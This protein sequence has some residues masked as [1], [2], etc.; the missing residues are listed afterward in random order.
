MSNIN[1][2]KGPLSNLETAAHSEGAL[3]F[4]LNND[5]SK[6]HLY[7]DNGTKYIN[8]VPE[9]LKI[10]NGGT[11]ATTAADALAN[12]GGLPLAGGTMTGN[13]IF[14]NS[15]TT[16]QKNE[17][18][19][20]WATI[21]SNKPYIGF[22]HDQT[23]GTFIICSTEKDTTTNGVKNY[24]N[25]L[26]IGGGTGNL[27][28]K[29]KQ[30][31]TTDMIP[32]I[33][34]SL[35]NPQALTIQGNGTTSFT[36]DGSAAKTL[37][38]KAGSN[39]SVSSDT[40]GNITINA[41][42]TTYTSLK[43]PYALTIQGNGTTLTNGIYDGSAAK[44][45][46]ITPAVIGAATAAQGIKA[47]NAMPKSGGTFTGAVT[48]DAFTYFNNSCYMPNGIAY[49][50]YNTDGTHVCMLQTGGS[51]DIIIGSDN[52]PHKGNTII[53]APNGKIILTTNTE[54][55]GDLSV[56][57]VIAS[58]TI[59][60]LW[61]SINGNGT[62]ITALTNSLTQTSVSYTFDTTNTNSTESEITCVAYKA[63]GLVYFSMLYTPKA[64]LSSST[65]Q[66]NIATINTN[67]KPID[68]HAIALS[69]NAVNDCSASVTS[70]GTVRFRPK[71]A[72]ADTAEVMITGVWKYKK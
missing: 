61:D 58:P 2:K 64:A 60:K 25:G 38:I 65:G 4:A 51:N 16:L 13:I 42:D 3:M 29:G 44:T 28:W 59:D 66:I 35:K 43:N 14:D 48:H 6:Y 72:F 8:V 39:V 68:G 67:Y 36:Y 49:N 63:I 18:Y 26:A 9:L 19:L 71:G 62:D 69:T 7:Y 27:L 45:V 54:I 52:Y 53:K 56:T 37:N 46:N 57:G 33:P 12:L 55:Q 15:S 40:S 17:P 24:K 5:S 11:N 1:L 34:T 21:G 23:D 47:D 30:I 20:Q 41:T 10:E 70:T 31:A 32:S 22:A 50:S